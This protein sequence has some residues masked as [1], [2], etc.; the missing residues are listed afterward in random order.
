[1][2]PLR[3][4]YLR[5]HVVEKLALVM[6]VI[7]AVALFFT[8]F[9]I[10]QPDRPP[11][12]Y[13]PLRGR[14]HITADP[15]GD[16]QLDAVDCFPGLDRGFSGIVI[17]FAPT[18]P[19]KEVH[20]DGSRDGD[21]V[22]SVYFADASKPPLQVHERDCEFIEGFDRVSRIVGGTRERQIRNGYTKFSCLKSGI[23]GRFTYEGCM[24]PP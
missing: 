21:N 1:M 22:V 16:I 5:L 7:G 12:L 13:A 4:W 9:V 10:N 18:Q 23:E 15:I 19:V 11:K 24:T 3:S 20:L 14:F 6:G 17:T 2:G 8:Y